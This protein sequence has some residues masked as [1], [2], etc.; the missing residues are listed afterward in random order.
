MKNKRLLKVVSLIVPLLCLSV[1]SFGQS[2]MVRGTIKDID[3]APLPGVTIV[4]KGTTQGT[5][6]DVDGAYTLKDVSSKGVLVYSFVGMR[7][8]EIAVNNQSVINVE[9][10]ADV[11]DLGEVVAV[12]YGVQRKEAVTGSVA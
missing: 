1:W 7:T 12:G 8:I 9:M 3:G 4:Q 10:L 11:T 6:S 5:I 2:L